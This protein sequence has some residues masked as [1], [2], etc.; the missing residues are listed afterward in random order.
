MLAMTGILRLFAALNTN[1]NGGLA[2][3][4]DIGF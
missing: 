4:A 1:A 2:A 3:G